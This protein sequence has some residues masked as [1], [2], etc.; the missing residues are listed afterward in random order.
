MRNGLVGFTLLALA[1]VGTSAAAEERIELKPGEQ[2][3]LDLKDLTRVALGDV[4]T[5]EV[6]TLGK[7]QLEVTGREAGTTK[8]LVWK[9]SGE[10]LE[11]SIVVTD[12]AAKEK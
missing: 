1:L 7:G 10:R 5:A 8:L 6:K 4:N 12:G 11:Y 3:V 9:K 2:R